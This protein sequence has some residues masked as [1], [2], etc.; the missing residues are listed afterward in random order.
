MLEVMKGRW[1]VSPPHRIIRNNLES[2]VVLTQIISSHH[3]YTY[4]K[5]LS[6]DG[7]VQERRNTNALQYVETNAAEFLSIRTTNFTKI[8]LS[9]EK[10]NKGI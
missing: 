7:L 3:T 4:V 2:L 1:V 9:E 10:L 8:T 5:Y 6:V